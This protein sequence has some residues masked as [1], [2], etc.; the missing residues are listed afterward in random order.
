MNSIQNDNKDSDEYIYN[1]VGII[2][3]DNVPVLAEFKEQRDTPLL[4]NTIGYKFT[5]AKFS[6]PADSLF[7]FDFKDN[8]YSVTLEYSG[9]YFRTYLV[10]VPTVLFNTDYQPVTSYQQFIDAINVALN[11]AFTNLKTAFPLAPPINSPRF[12]YNGY[13]EGLSLIVDDTYEPTITPNTISIFFNYNL[14]SFVPSFYN[15]AYSYN[16][17]NG[18]DV[19]LL[20]KDLVYNYDGGI[21]EMKQEYPT[22]YKWYDIRKIIVVSNNINVSSQS[23]SINQS[24]K[25]NNYNIISDFEPFQFG[26]G[27]SLTKSDYIYNPNF[28][29]F[30]DLKN[31]TALRVVDFQFLYQS[32][33]GDIFPLYINPTHTMSVKLLFVKKDT[34]TI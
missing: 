33:Y 3:R 30:I 5:V 14:Y 11:T 32:K 7:I 13:S 9:T 26:L 21:I 28:Y 12:Q 31:S 8:T 27:D 15:E 29:R 23:I 17:I 34:Q 25:T 4:D 16:D 19:K 6:L 2:N 24:G 1:D 10:Y 20:V 18:A 22:F